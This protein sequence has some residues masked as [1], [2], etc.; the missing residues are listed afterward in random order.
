MKNKNVKTAMYM[1]RLLEGVKDIRQALRKQTETEQHA[2]ELAEEAIRLKHEEKKRETKALA[3]RTDEHSGDTKS[4]WQRFAGWIKEKSSF[5]DWLVTIFTAALAGA[6]IYTIIIIG[7]QL[8]VMRKDQRPWIKLTFDSFGVQVNSPIGGNL[9]I[10]N[11]G[12]TVAKN[13][14]GQ[15]EVAE[16]RNGEQARM[17]Y[18]SASVIFTTGA[19]FPNDPQVRGIPLQKV[20]QHSPSGDTYEPIMLS[21]TEY[22][23]FTNGKIFFVAYGTISYSDFF[24]IQHWTKYCTFLTAANGPPGVF[25]AKNCTDYNDV[26]DN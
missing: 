2:Q 4:R 11:Y 12:K 8:D 3:K 21:Q 15:F 23:D 18:G 7:G 10:V 26:D 16:V 24:R 6:T 25:T 9:R 19:L 22:N 13:I 14:T 17:E 20:A 1:R 5:T